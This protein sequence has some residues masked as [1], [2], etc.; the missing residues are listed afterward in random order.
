MRNRKILAAVHLYPPKHL[1]GGEMYLHRMLKHLQGKGHEV[2]VLLLNSEHY[3]V[4]SV[5]SYDG[6]EVYPNDRDVVRYCLDWCDMMVTHLDYTATVIAYG[7]QHR[8][9]VL[10]LVHNSFRGAASAA[11][12]NAEA[13]QY[14]VYNTEVCRWALNYKHPSITVH[15]P[16]DFRKWQSKKS[17]AKNEFITLVN[18]DQN[19][20]GH[21][22]QQIAAAMPGRKFLGVMGSYSEPAHIGQHVRQPS[23]VVVMPKTQYMQTNVYDRTRLLIMPSKYESWG[24]TA[25]EAAANGIPVICTNL[26]GLRENLAEAGIYIDNRDDVQAWVKAIEALDKAETYKKRSEA[27]KR[28]A[29]ELDPLVELDAL[30][31]FIQHKV[32]FIYTYQ[33]KAAAVST[34]ASI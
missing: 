27:V 20:G 24:M 28:R 31:D 6:V 30:A 26:P 13:Q 19:K 10:H 29:K 1:C 9:P 5:Y 4:R 34:A 32:R 33:S 11:I 17:P 15:P 14:I 22:L 3:N 23:N 8:K 21:I 2:R 18:L 25:T 12:D 7:L 16:V